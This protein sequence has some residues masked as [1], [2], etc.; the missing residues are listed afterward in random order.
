MSPIAWL[1]VS[2]SASI[3][4]VCA[5]FPAVMLLHRAMMA[6]VWVPIEARVTG[7]ILYVIGVPADVAYNI[8]IGTIRF[9]EL[10]RLLSGELTM[11]ARVQRHVDESD[12]WR[13]DHAMQWAAFLNFC[14]PG[15]I[16]VAR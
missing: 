6:G 16:K 4:V 14:D 2:I 11:S 8:V 5:A 7:R 15:H 9:R 10:P 12:G 1:C 3:F 13:L